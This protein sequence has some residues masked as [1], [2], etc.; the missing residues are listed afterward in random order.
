MDKRS[1]VLDAARSLFS[2]FGLNKVTTD[3]ISRHAG[4][5]KATL[6]KVYSNKQEIFDEVI[7]LETDHLIR[8]IVDASDTESTTRGRL[9]AYLFA[10][11][12]ALN[13]LN[14]LFQVTRFTFGNFWPHIADARDRVLDE[15][16]RIVRQILTTGVECGEVSV[17]DPSLTA[18]VLVASFSSLEF[19]WALGGYD[20]SLEEHV[21]HL[22]D[23]VVSGL[24]HGSPTGRSR[25]TTTR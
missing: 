16:K 1:Q 11:L 6:Y 13:H 14:N 7:A 24:E 19:D 4:I 3:D 17:P 18:H 12:D 20:V 5:S 10:K 9:R 15:E 22:L 8:V 23:I 21:D 2:Q 25:K